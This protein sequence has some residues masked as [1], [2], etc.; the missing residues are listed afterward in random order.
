MQH[1]A[2]DYLEVGRR[3]SKDKLMLRPY[4]DR[5]RRWRRQEASGS[6]RYRARSRD[7]QEQVADPSDSENRDNTSQELGDRRLVLGIDADTHGWVFD[8]VKPAEARA[9]G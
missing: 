4:P 8:R 1:D 5:R 9:E 6:P 7:P 3:I 2:S